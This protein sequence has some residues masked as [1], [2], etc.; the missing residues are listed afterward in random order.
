MQLARGLTGDKREPAIGAADYVPPQL[1]NATAF[2]A[3]PCATVR[4]CLPPA[5][6]ISTV[7]PLA[8]AAR[9][10][11]ADTAGNADVK[12]APTCETLGISAS[13]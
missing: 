11:A 3:A 7:F 4:V 2:T 1:A 9:S 6:Q 5:F 8:I 13:S 10:P 12:S